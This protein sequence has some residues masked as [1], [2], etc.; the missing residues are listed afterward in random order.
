[1]GWGWGWGWGMGGG[2][3]G[4]WMGEFLLVGWS[5]GCLS[6]CPPLSGCLAVW[7]FVCLSGWLS[8]CLSGWLST[9]LPVCLSLCLCLAVCLVASH[10]V[11]VVVWWGGGGSLQSV[12]SRVMGY[13]MWHPTPTLPQ[14]SSF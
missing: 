10:V 12:I 4:G 8:V 9:C 11:I 7:F 5:V 1:M 13:P 6:V 14:P 2:G 3:V